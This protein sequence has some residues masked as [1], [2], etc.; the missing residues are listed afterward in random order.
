MP[1]LLYGI[2]VWG[3]TPILLDKIDRVQRRAVDAGV[4][5]ILPDEFY[6]DVFMALLGVILF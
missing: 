3:C 5:Y 6:I 2:Q 1:I 4:I